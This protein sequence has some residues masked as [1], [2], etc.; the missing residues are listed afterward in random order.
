MSHESWEIK[1]E[2]QFRRSE[3]SALYFMEQFW[4]VLEVGKGWRKFHPWPH[5]PGIIIDMETSTRDIGARD[6]SL[7]A[8]QIG[9]TTIGCGVAM[10]DCLFHENH[11]WLIVSQGLNESK[12]TLQK[13]VIEPYSR[14]PKWIR[15][16]LPAIT[17]ETAESIEFAN[18]SSITSIP[19]TA[20]S[21]RGDAV[22]GTI[23]DEAA[24][25][26]DADSVFAALDPLTYGPMF[27]FSTANGMGNLFHSTYMS[28]DLPNA[29]W[30][31]NFFPWSVV[32]GRDE[33]WYT[34]K[35]AVYVNAKHLLAQ[36]YPSTDVEAFLKSG[37]VALPVEQMQ[38]EFCW[39]E[40]VSRYDLALINDIDPDTFTRSKIPVGEQSPALELRVWEEPHIERDDKGRMVREPNYVIGADIAEGLEHGD[41]NAIVVANA[42]TGDRVATVKAHVPIH[43]MGMLLAAIG[44]WYHNALLIVERNNTG[45][46]P[47]EYLRMASYPRLYRMES[48]A[49]QQRSDRTPRYGWVTS[50]ATKPMLVHQYVNAISIGAIELHD[51]RLLAEAT[52]YLADGKGGFGATKP[53]HDDLLMADMICQRG[54]DDVALHPPIFYDIDPG[55]VTF[56]ELFGTMA[57]TDHSGGS[58]LGAPIGQRY[59]DEP[60]I[61]S[62]ILKEGNVL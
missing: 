44:Y 19:S 54:I 8:R 28:A 31:R 39:C 46:V 57:P 52:T 25:M 4:K 12:K 32:P 36:E 61:S 23:F 29:I 15:E 35:E 48:F 27:M 53:N 6:V 24:F 60:V 43:L 50:P 14:L 9:F 22:W 16:R 18:G 49:A 41:Y 1:R 55:P 21:G 33:Q 51:R 56:G 13:K 2:F 47:L 5:Q 26:E 3:Q 30:K 17:R 40:P 59:K 20:S 11:P 58:A 37:R 45:L 42:Y 62:I 38:H 34:N 7:K 10:W